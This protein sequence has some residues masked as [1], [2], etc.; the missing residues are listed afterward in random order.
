MADFNINLLK[1]QADFSCF[2]FLNSLSNHFMTPYIL[3]PSKLQS[4]T[5]IDNIFFNSIEF[6]SYSGNLLY[7]ISDHLSQ[8]NEN[9]FDELVI[10]SLDWHEICNLEKNDPN[11]SLKWFID[12]I[13]YYLDEMAPLRKMTNKKRKSM[14]KPC[15]SPQTF[16]ENVKQSD[17]LLKSIV[18]KTDPDNVNSLHNQYKRL[19]NIITKLKRESKTSYN[20]SYFEKYT[21]ECQRKFGLE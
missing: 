15:V 17:S 19:R 7:E 6:K 5:L 10:Q 13:N 4:K 9:E 16:W 21:N 18:D 20:F 3:Q 11:H 1:A 14:F 12:T 8:F 2:T